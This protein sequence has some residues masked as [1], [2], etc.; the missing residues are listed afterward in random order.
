MSGG[1]QT[2]I[3]GEN[4]SVLAQ[5]VAIDPTAT[6]GEII[7]EFERLTG[8]LIHEQTLISSLHGH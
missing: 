7:A 2:K 4:E 8:L 6:S 5:I 3:S 1:R